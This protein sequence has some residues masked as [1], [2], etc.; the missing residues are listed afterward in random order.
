MPNA[1]CTSLHTAFLISRA[2]DGLPAPGF[3]DIAKGLGRF[4]GDP[5]SPDA[6][7]SHDAMF[8]VAAAFWSA[9]GLPETSNTA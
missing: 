6:A 5:S 4:S 1:K 7:T 2:R 9:A 3:F 8:A